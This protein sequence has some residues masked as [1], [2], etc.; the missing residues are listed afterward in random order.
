MSLEVVLIMGLLTKSSE[1][2]RLAPTGLTKSFWRSLS[3]LLHRVG[4]S[5]VVRISSQTVR[6]SFQVVRTSSYLVRAC[7][8]LICGVSLVSIDQPFLY[9]LQKTHLQFLCDEISVKNS[10]NYCNGVNLESFQMGWLKISKNRIFA[11]AKFK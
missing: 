11:Q 6:G 1:V 8:D 4:S 5:Q 9:L 10:W 7:S 3:L 2:L